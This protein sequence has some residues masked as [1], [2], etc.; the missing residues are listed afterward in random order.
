[1]GHYSA[2]LILLV[3]FSTDKK[4]LYNQGY[5]AAL[6]KVW[7]LLGAITSKFNGKTFPIKFP[8]HKLRQDLEKK[9]GC[10]FAS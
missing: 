4:T 2:R 1:M 9:S 6:V 8:P 10:N 5:N 3:L 7:L